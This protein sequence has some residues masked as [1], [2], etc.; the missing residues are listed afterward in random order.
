MNISVIWKMKRYALYSESMWWNIKRNNWSFSFCSLHFSLEVFTEPTPCNKEKV[1]IENITTVA[2]VPQQSTIEM[3]NSIFNVGTTCI[4]NQ[5]PVDDFSS[6][7]FFRR[8]PDDAPN[9]ANRK[10]TAPVFWL[11]YGLKCHKPL[12]LTLPTLS[13]SGNGRSVART[14]LYRQ[15]FRLARLA[16]ELGKKCLGTPLENLLHPYSRTAPRNYPYNDVTT[17]YFLSRVYP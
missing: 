17:I 15:N 14:D 1:L 2:S 6:F 8:F 11:Q 4:E 7:P 13:D 5:L 12:V 16:N 10:C 3:N 9:I